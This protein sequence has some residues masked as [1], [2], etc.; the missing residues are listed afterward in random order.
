MS[1]TLITRVAASLAVVATF[2]G[3]VADF[4]G[5]YKIEFVIEG[6]AYSGTASAAAAPSG[7][8]AFTGKFE[9]TAPS[10]V[11]AEMTG[12]TVGDSLT[13]DAKYDDKT[14]GCTG[15]LTGKGVIE[16][17]G[18]KA[19]GALAINDSCGGS[20]GGTFRLWR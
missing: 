11:L 20:I 15:T 10:S 4:K 8:G 12:K 9:L 3:R 1:L 19:S 5:D 6:T 13:Y 17:D 7:K 2:S 14:R 16:K 18:S